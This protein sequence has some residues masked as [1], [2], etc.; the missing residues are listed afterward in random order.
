MVHLIFIDLARYH[1]LVSTVINTCTLLYFYD[2]YCCLK[3]THTNNTLPPYL[4]NFLPIHGLITINLFTDHLAPF[5]QVNCWCIWRQ[6]CR[7]F[8]QERNLRSRKK[9]L[10]KREHAK[11]RYCLS[12]LRRKEKNPM[13]DSTK[14]KRRSRSTLLK[15][16]YISKL[17]KLATQYTIFYARHKIPLWQPWMFC[18]LF[19]DLV[20]YHFFV[21]TVIYYTSISTIVKDILKKNTHQQHNSICS[22]I[23]VHWLVTEF[24]R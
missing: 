18:F 21:S 13:A 3:K 1:F 8:L 22:F 12:R 23:K 24:N 6:K 11:K 5:W 17:Y 10:K 19:I 20:R 14:N 4:L 2:S 9:K 16:K 7:A 15:W